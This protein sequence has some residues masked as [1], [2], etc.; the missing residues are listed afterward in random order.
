MGQLEP[1]HRGSSAGVIRA[2]L[3]LRPGTPGQQYKIDRVARA[4]QYQNAWR[5]DGFL[6]GRVGTTFQQVILLSKHQPI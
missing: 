5:R 6:T 2:P 4:Q 3:A 1:L